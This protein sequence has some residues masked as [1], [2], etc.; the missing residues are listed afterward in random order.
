MGC[1]LGLLV[2]QLN[3]YTLAPISEERISEAAG[4]NSAAGSFGLS[5]G[6]AMAGSVMLATLAI[7]FTNLT[8]ASTVIP[9]AEK[10]T[11]ATVLDDDAQLMSNTQLDILL[12]T[13]PEAIQDEIIRI[14]TEARPIALQVAL[15]V[16]LI[17]GHPRADHL[18]PDGADARRGAAQGGRGPRPRVTVELGRGPVMIAAQH[19]SETTE[20]TE[21]PM[22][23]P[24][25]TQPRSRKPTAAKIAGIIGI[26][27][28]VLIIVGVWLG[29]GTVSRTIDDLGNSV[30]AGFDRAIAATDTVSNGLNETVASLASMRAEAAELV[31][32]RPDPER[33]AGLQARLGQI[34]DRYRDLRTRYVEARESVVG[35]TATVGRVAQLIPGSRVPE[36]AGDRLVAVDAKLQAVDDALVSTWTRLSEVDPGRRRR[37]SSRTAPRPCRMRSPVPPRPSTACPRTSRASRPTPTRPST[38]SG[39]SS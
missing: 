28:C 21:T 24:V 22:F 34:A 8:D 4:V 33:F 3:N 37:M 11:V 38:A 19:E 25:P 27:I 13:Q 32:G 14:N 5:F 7:V 36:G 35:V 31:A 23:K 30:N 20:M 9:P 12:A 16:P 10:Q 26:V 17:A 6:L 39:R 29:L 18:V 2:S 1:G 15:L